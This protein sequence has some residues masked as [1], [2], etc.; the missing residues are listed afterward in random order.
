MGASLAHGIRASFDADAWIVAL[1]DMPRIRVATIRAV[2]SALATGA[3]IAAPTY[4]G[5]RG[6]PVGFAGALRDALAA[7]SGDA[8]AR[9][10]LRTERGRVQLM[11]CD[12]AGVLADVDTPADLA[13][14]GR[15]ER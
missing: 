3:I 6:H 4:R 12:D 14:I 7:L 2:A 13:Q 11:D 9:E 15:D 1:G 5:T 10:V 8:G